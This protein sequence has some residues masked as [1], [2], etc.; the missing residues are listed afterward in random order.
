MPR[1]S[2]QRLQQ[3]RE[4]ILDAGMRAFIASGFQA[5][6]TADIAR[7][8]NISEGLIYRY[9][10]SKRALLLMVLRRFSD[11]LFEKV[12]ERVLPLPGFEARLTALIDHYLGSLIAQPEFTR[13]YM[14]EI[15]SAAV[16]GIDPQKLLTERSKLLW[17]RMVADGVEAGDISPGIDN[18]LTRELIWATIETTAALRIEGTIDLPTEALAE[19]LSA[20]LMRG[21]V[22]Q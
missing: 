9:F 14:A 20:L 19:K 12:E 4:S 22:A 5:A 3:R 1:V 10:P 7:L 8:A 6:S 15:R 11:T 16:D 2:A 13:L 17:R 21:L 18:R